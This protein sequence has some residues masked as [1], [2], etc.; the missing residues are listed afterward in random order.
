[1][2]EGLHKI[3]WLVTQLKRIVFEL[4]HINLKDTWE[5]I[6]LYIHLLES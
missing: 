2:V 1:M 3:V 6:P 5:I 4:C